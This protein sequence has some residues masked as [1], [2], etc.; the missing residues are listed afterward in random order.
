MNNSHDLRLLFESRIPIVAIETWEEPRALQLLSR[1][2]IQMS[3]P[4]YAWSVTEGLRRID[5]DGAAKLAHTAEPE[6]V[7]KHIRA[8]ESAGIYAL[9]DFHPYLVNEPINI[10]LLKEIAMQAE[11]TGQR[12]ALVSHALDIPPECKRLSARFSLAMPEDHKLL[13]AVHREAE[14]FAKDTGRKVKTNRDA[15]NKLVNNLRGLPLADARKLARSAIYQD[16]A[17]THS[18]LQAVNK[19]KFELMDMEGVLSFEFDTDSFANVGGLNSLRKW[20]HKREHAFLKQS[21]DAPR[22]IMLV[23]VQGGGK[24]LAAKAVAGLWGLPLLRMDMGALY[25]KF[26]G[27]SERN[28][29]EA[30]ALADTMSPCVLWI[31]EIE[32]GIGGDN[33]DGGTARRVLGTLLTWMA[34]KQHAVFIVATAN[35]IEHLP[36]ELIRKGR[37]DE[38]F[39][40]DLP[41]TEVREEIFRIHL[42]KRD[43]S[44]E[45]FELA[46]MAAASDGFTG[47]EI[48]QAI[49]SAGYTARAREEVLSSPHII[50]EIQNTV[51]L[52][53][54]MA[55]KL[56]ALR[57]WCSDRAVAAE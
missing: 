17:I 43:Y 20:L 10:R 26:F 33:H 12:L 29:R 57:H 22:G 39:F 36:P 30:L 50:E 18:D 24:S 49:V 5:Y 13:A 41:S 19:A 1:L 51:P 6:A 2:G 53:I 14:Q 52:S 48:E 47:A 40:V 55:E 25:N 34:E 44:P 45:E 46:A 11:R 27:E 23:G 3:T 8:S 38:I 31:D 15:L 9:C 32:K 28:V 42:A 56:A 54:T 35:E 21:R 7:L 4:V 16:G 37:L